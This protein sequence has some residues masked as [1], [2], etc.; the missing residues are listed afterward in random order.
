MRAVLLVHADVED[1]IINKEF[2]NIES[3]LKHYSVKQLQTR[4][5]FNCNFFKISPRNISDS[6]YYYLAYSSIHMCFYKLQGFK[7]NDFND[8]YNNELLAGAVIFDKSITG[9][10]KTLKYILDNTSINEI[11]IRYLYNRYYN[12][13]KMCLM[14]KSS[15]T[16][17][18][19]IVEY[20]R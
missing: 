19:T 18:K 11:D 5:L 6:C 15:C 12:K 9:N 16:R 17:K 13:P 1:F 20:K 7:Y 10:R 8:F 3:V 2:M 14:D 4:G